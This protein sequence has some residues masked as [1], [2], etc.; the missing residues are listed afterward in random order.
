[1]SEFSI[2]FQIVLAILT[3]AVPALVGWVWALWRD[4]TALKLKVAEEYMH[5]SSLS[6][7]K[8]EIKALRDVVYR[9]ALK[10]DVP[11]FTEPFR[12]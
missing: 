2:S 9:I 12:R 10:M 5:H 6:E 3:I 7:V 4:H 8:E 11:V 1:M